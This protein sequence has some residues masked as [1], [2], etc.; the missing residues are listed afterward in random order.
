MLDRRRPLEHVALELAA[1]RIEH[2]F[3]SNVIVRLAD[4]L[5]LSSEERDVLA[6]LTAEREAV[7]AFAAGLI[8]E[9]SPDP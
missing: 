4:A 5:Y 7:A 8:A 2:H 9:L 1:L 6:L 3:L